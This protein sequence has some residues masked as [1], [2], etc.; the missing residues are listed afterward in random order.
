[1]LFLKYTTALSLLMAFAGL[2]TTAAAEQAIIGLGVGNGLELFVHMDETPQ[3]GPHHREIRLAANGEK[4]RYDFTIISHD[5]DVPSD[6]WTTHTRRWSI[7][8]VAASWTKEALTGAWDINRSDDA[9]WLKAVTRPAK[10]E[11]A[12]WSLSAECVKKGGC[13]GEKTPG[14]GTAAFPLP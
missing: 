6:Q 11:I 10:S 3:K 8:A 9:D 14:L 4:Q 7:K 2:G 13:D 12:V 1:M 5:P